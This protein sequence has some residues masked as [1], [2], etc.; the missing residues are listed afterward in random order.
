M[1]DRRILETSAAPSGIDWPVEVDFE[2][3][4][5]T[6]PDLADKDDEAM[7]FHWHAYGRAEGRIASPV[8]LSENFIALAPAEALI[9]EIGPFTNPKFTG[10]NIRYFDL[11]DG[12]ALRR[13]GRELDRDVSRVPEI[14]HYTPSLEAARGAGLD[15]VF[16]CHN[17]EHH[18]DLILHLQQAGAALRPGGIYMMVVPDR[19]YCFDH[20]LPDLTVARVIGAHLDKRTVHAPSSVIEHRAFT[21]HNDVNRHWA[22][23]HGPAPDGL[24]GS[25]AFA[26][27]ELEEAQGGYV[28]VHA[29][30]FTPDGL[31]N[32]IAGLHAL[33]YSPFRPLRVYDTP[34]GRNEFTAVL[35]LDPA[36]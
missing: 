30:Q 19:R 23:D 15:V 12:D 28:D 4:R 26:L 20:F 34:F 8:A 11:L 6:Y 7:R 10:P 25:V 35:V 17:I 9:L 18:P 32:A 1:T 33:G 2:V 3:L 21:C 27:K 36:A 13:W 29:W 14:I 16:S 5:A 24:G 31:R 22:G